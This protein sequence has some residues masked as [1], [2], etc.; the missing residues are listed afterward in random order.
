[1]WSKVHLHRHRWAQ[2]TLA[3]GETTTPESGNE[4]SWPVSSEGCPRRAISP[5]VWSVWDASNWRNQSQRVEEGE[6]TGTVCACGIAVFLCLRVWLCVHVLYVCIHVGV[7]NEFMLSL[8]TSWTWELAA[9][10]A[11][12]L[13]GFWTCELPAHSRCQQKIN[14]YGIYQ[15]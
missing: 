12:P 8:T 13:L 9:A 2:K 6:A 1:M 7:C 11:S 10:A 3:S 14:A 4:A 15:R 5:Y